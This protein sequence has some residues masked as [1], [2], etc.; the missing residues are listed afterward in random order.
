MEELVEAARLRYSTCRSCNE[1][2]GQS[3]PAEGP[4][5]M[6]GNC[7]MRHC[8]FCGS[9]VECC[10]HFVYTT[11]E[12]DADGFEPELGLVPIDPTLSEANELEHLLAARL[13]A[14]ASLM[15]YFLDYLKGQDWTR[16]DETMLLMEILSCLDEPV[17]SLP[18]AGWWMAASSGTDHF[19]EHGSAAWDQTEEVWSELKRT[20]SGFPAPAEG[21]SG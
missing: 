19:A 2:L 4:N 6:C 3:D 16:W 5:L 1:P 21:P 9:E 7:G 11:G 20:L 10:E 14:H 18:W 15:P 17:V 13:G 12:I 8:P